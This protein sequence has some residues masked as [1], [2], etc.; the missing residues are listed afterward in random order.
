M[1]PVI[2]RVTSAYSHLVTAENPAAQ[3]ARTALR[4]AALRA[5]RAT[6]GRDRPFLPIREDLPE[7][8]N[9]RGLLGIG[10]EVGVRDGEFSELILSGWRGARL[11]S[12]DPWREAAPDEYVDLANV[13]QQRQDQRHED[14]K[15]R[16]ARF[17]DR[18][19]VW[20]EYS[21]RAARSVPLDSADFVYIDARHDYASVKEDLEAWFPAVRQGG[22]LAGHDY[23]D[24]TFPDGIFGVRSAVNEFFA[25]RG[26]RVFSTPLDPPWPTWVVA[27]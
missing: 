18:S 13:E 9:R 14:T 20:R 4:S 23:V 15:A 19:E 21:V 16:L 5:S 6:Y 24:G 27:K 10:Y 1:T 2:D 17:G 12:V 7:L 11:I 3:R 8:L 26:L 25:H 22:V